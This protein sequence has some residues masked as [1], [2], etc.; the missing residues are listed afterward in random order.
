VITVNRPPQNGSQAGNRNFVEVIISQNAPT[1]FLR[2]LGIAS[3]T[4]QARAVAGLVYDPGYCVYVL[5]PGARWALTVEGGAKLQTSCGVMVNSDDPLALIENGG[6]CVTAGVIDV[7]GGYAGSCYSPT[8]NTDVPP[9]DDPLADL[10]PPSFSGCNYENFKY[11]SGSDVTLSPGVY[12]GGIKINSTG[13]IR[14]NPGTYIIN[15]GG[16]TI[17]A[18]QINGEGVSFYLTESL[19]NP[20]WRYQ[21]VSITGG[22][23][24]LSAPTTGPMAGIL[25]FQDRNVLFDQFNKIV[26]NSNSSFIGAIYFPTQELMYAGTSGV[27]GYTTLIANTLKF[28]GDTDVKNYTPDM[29]YAPPPIKKAAMVE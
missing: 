28:A 18:G 23:I 17:N 27:D 22:N 16:F 9:E 12:C 6:G 1:F 13:K 29:A 3:T 21:P 14:F 5:D 15:G 4:V 11:N 2:V 10:S 20:A 26:G 7:T 25:F 8:P 24:N 19:I